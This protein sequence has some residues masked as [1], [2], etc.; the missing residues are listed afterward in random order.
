MHIL[1]HV[2]RKTEDEATIDDEYEYDRIYMEY[3][4]R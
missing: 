4:D 1:V 3:Q 2:P